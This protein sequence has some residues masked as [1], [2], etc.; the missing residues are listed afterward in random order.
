MAHNQTSNSAPYTLTP[1]PPM[2]SGISDLHL[3]LLVP[4]AVH[5]LT[6]AVFE[7]CE[8]TGWLEQYRL[9]SSAEEQARNRVT[10]RDCLR[11]T[12]QCQ[13]SPCAYCAAG[14][15]EEYELATY[16]GGVEAAWAVGTRLLYPTGI[17]LKTLGSRLSKSLSRS[18]VTGLGQPA[19]L[20]GS[21]LYW[22]IVP[23]FQFFFAI[24]VAD[25][26]MYCLHRLGH[27]NKWIYKHIHSQHHRLYVPYSWGGSYNHPFDSLVVDGLSYA[28]GFWATGISN[29][30]S[31]F[32]LGYASFKNVLD[33]AGYQF[34]WNPIAW[35]T[36]MDASFHD[37][38]HQSWGLKTNFGV[39]FGIWDRIM[40]THF[41]NQE[42]VAN[43]RSRTRISAEEAAAHPEK[44]I[45]SSI[46]KERKGKGR[47][48]E[49]D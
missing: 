40:G 30:L 25:A 15:S 19:V 48:N 43:L 45:S 16:I 18:A 32:L 11:T 24:V 36:G 22:Y 12:L 47:R 37:V 8:R 9:H 3:S 27:T 49:Q 4:F 41:D 38:H 28:L 6:S 23:A 17:D 21:L 20:V 13:A 34:P 29:R 31:I 35:A 26:F 1:K 33:H 39:H 46:N 44:T 10:R 7:L 42:L 5:W 2:V 14:P